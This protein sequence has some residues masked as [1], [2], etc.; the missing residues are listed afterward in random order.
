MEWMN[1]MMETQMMMTFVIM[2]AIFLYV[3]ME[4]LK[5]QSSVTT[6]IAELSRSAHSTHVGPR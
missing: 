6:I 5:G 3:V 2:L 4:T 1:V